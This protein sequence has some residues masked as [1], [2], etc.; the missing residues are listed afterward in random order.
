MAEATV[1]GHGEDRHGPRMDR[2]VKLLNRPLVAGTLA[3]TGPSPTNGLTFCPH[4][5]FPLFGL[6]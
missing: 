2:A 1:W 5:P 4:S 3:L 6:L